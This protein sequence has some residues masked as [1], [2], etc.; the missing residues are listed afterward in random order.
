VRGEGRRCVVVGLGNAF[1]G[2]DGAGLLA[3]ERLRERLAAGAPAGLVEVHQHEG[4]CDTLLELWRGAPSTIVLDAARTGAPP[5]T[6][7]R[8]DVSER[9]LGKAL[10]SGG[11]GHLVDLAGAIELARALGRL[12]SRTIVLA[13][14]GERF[15]LGTQLS[16]A[17]ATGVAELVEA[18]ARELDE[19]V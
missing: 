5:G 15:E 9:P 19:V 2:D 6:I 13:L 10:G 16:P 7:T 14:E 12:P 4:E 3:A 17:V 1:R 18:A 8:F 11:A